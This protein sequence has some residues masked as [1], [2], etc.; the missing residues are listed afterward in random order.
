MEARRRPR[1]R[2]R[3]PLLRRELALHRGQAGILRALLRP[4]AAAPHV[5]AGDR[6]AV[7]PRV[8]AGDVRRCCAL[9]R[10]SLRLLGAVCVAGIAASIAAMAFAVRRPATRRARTTAPTPARTR[11]SIGALLAICSRR[12]SRARAARRDLRIAAIVAFGSDGDRVGRRRPAPSARYYHGGSAA[13]RG[14]RVH[15]DRRR[16]CNPASCSARCR[17]RPLAWIGR[18]SYGLYLFH[19]PIVGLAGAD[20]RAP[21][22]RR[23]EPAAARAHVRRG[24]AQLL[25]GRAPDPGATP[26]HACP[27]HHGRCAATG[28]G[29]APRERR[30][31]WLAIPA[32]AATLAIVLAI[33]D[34]RV[35]RAELPGR[36][37]PPAAHLLL[38]STS[39]DRST[40]THGSAGSPADVPVHPRPRRPC[41]SRRT[42]SRL[43]LVV[44][45]PA[46]LRH[47]APERDERG[48]RRGAP[49]RHRSMSRSQAAGLRI[50]LVGDSTACSLF[51]GLNAVGDEAG[52]VRRP[53]R[54]LR[55]RRGQR[56]DH[57]DAQRADHPA[58]RALPGA[59]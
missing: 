24:D 2:D 23:A 39:R 49:A 18:I 29:A 28:A 34:G 56:R 42:P 27:W 46:L 52:G 30:C 51:P 41:S 13:V 7:L 19:W 55:L 33:H 8:A 58:H 16:S 37:P 44:R 38:A 54:G 15:R 53:G 26:A 50:L 20:A 36:S 4:V 6:G 22:R 17:S 59:W 11:S 32:V 5:V 9:A 45:R 3:E 47:A 14:A 57:D 48:G 21:A 10:G 43:P 31:A 12:G 35:P 40:P 25:P 1:R